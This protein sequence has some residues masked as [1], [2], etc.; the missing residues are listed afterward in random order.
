MH[1]VVT[2]SLGRYKPIILIIEPNGGI[3]DRKYHN[4]PG[5]TVNE[6]VEFGEEIGYELIGMSGEL[7]RESGNLY[8]IRN[9]FKSGKASEEKVKDTISRIHKASNIIPVSYTHLTL[10]TSDLV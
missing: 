6:L 4:Q 7:H 2:R 1:L 8:F 9:D 10:P 3:Y 5:S